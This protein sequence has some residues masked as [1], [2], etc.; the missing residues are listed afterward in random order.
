[1]PVVVRRYK[2]EEAEALP[3][4]LEPESDQL[5]VAAVDVE[6]RSIIWTPES[7]G[8][9]EP[10]YSYV[11]ATGPGRPKPDGTRVPMPFKR[12]DLLHMSGRQLATAFSYRGYE[13]Y[14][15]SAQSVAAKIDK[16]E[17]DKVVA[18]AKEGKFKTADPAPVKLVTAK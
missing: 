13:V 8:A 12:G 6:G 5:V 15:V 10:M 7:A 2:L 3:C 18:A 17:L 4:F 11:M 16:E 14:V 9:D 1:M